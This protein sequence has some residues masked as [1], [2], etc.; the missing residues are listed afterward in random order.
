MENPQR[1]LGAEKIKKKNMNKST[2]KSMENQM[3]NPPNK[4]TLSLGAAKNKFIFYLGRKKTI[5]NMTKAP[6]NR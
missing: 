3:E 1:K 2:K 4:F 5:K 6:K